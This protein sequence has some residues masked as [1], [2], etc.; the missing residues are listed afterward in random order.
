MISQ[1]WLRH[2]AEVTDGK[3]IWYIAELSG[4]LMEV[5]LHFKELKIIWKIPN[6]VKSCSYR[7]L[8]YYNQKI[9]IFPYYQRTIYIYDLNTA[10][11]EK[12]DVKKSLELMGIIKRDCF[13]YGFGNK[14]KI[15]KFNLV[16]NTVVYIDMQEKLCDL[17]GIPLNWFW[18]KACIWNKCIYIPV[19]HSNILIALDQYDN[20]SS[21]SLGDKLED[22]IMENI[23]VDNGQYHVIYCKEEKNNLSTYVSEY[24]L[25]GKLLRESKIEEK[26]SYQMYPFVDAIWTGNNWICL[27]YGRNKILLRGDIDEKILFEI[28]NGTD[29]LSDI[30]QGLFHCSVRVNNNLI[31]SINQSTG[32]FI[33]ITLNDLSVNNSYLKLEENFPCL[34]EKSYQDAIRFHSAIEEMKNFYDLKSYINYICER[35]K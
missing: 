23:I 34:L 27:P 3:R 21:V 26:Y 35:K 32:S 19:S 15:L 14:S 5:N 20:V 31:C 17:E 25:N 4:F 24:S 9:Y 6:S 2:D 16:D 18:T 8:F 33:C 22:W 28:D 12:I 13:L 11:Y 1:Y 29:F 30:V 10:E 7:V